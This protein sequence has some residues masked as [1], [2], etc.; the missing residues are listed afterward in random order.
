MDTF[1]GTDATTGHL[2][3]GL[4]ANGSAPKIDGTAHINYHAGTV[5]ITSNDV[6]G[7]L[8]GTWYYECH[9]KI[10]NL[11]V[12]ADIYGTIKS[13]TS[14]RIYPKTTWP[15]EIRSGGTQA[16]VPHGVRY[17]GQTA[18]GYVR[19]PNAADATMTMSYLHDG[20]FNDGIWSGV[21][22]ISYGLIT[23]YKV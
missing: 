9:G 11:F 19:V 6:N 10:V 2:H 13:P 1:F 23:Y 4:D 3:T 12:T 14:L 16:E 15:A 20:T 17:G 18:M 5:D 22:G 7:G 8:N 21:C